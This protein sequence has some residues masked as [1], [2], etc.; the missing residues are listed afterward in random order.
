MTEPRRDQWGRPMILQ[1]D[2]KRRG[3][4]RATTLAKTLEDEAGLANWKMRQVCVGLATRA[5][6][7]AL[8]STAN[9]DK[10]KLNNVAKSALDAAASDSRANLGTALHALVETVVQG[11]EP[12]TVLDGLAGDLDAF[13]GVAKTL[14]LSSPETFVVNDTWQVAGTFDFLV[15]VGKHWRIGDLKTGTDL[16]YSWR[17]I[18]VQLATYANAEWIYNVDADERI[19]MP[20]IDKT[21][22]V[23][24]HLPAGEARCQLFEVD[25][26]AGLE[27]AQRSLWTRNWRKAKVSWQ[28]E[29]PK[30]TEKALEA[31]L[32]ARDAPPALAEPFTT[33]HETTEAAKA[34]R[35]WLTGRI[36]AL[37]AIDGGLAA[38]QAFWPA[39][40][41]TFKQSDAHTLD[42]LALI[43]T[44]LGAAEAKVA[45][46][47]EAEAPDLD[48]RHEAKVDM[49]RT[50]PAA[51]EANGFECNVPAVR[52]DG[53]FFGPIDEGDAADEAEVLELRAKI[54]AVESLRSFVSQAAKDANATGASIAMNVPTRR[55]HAIGR[56]LLAVARDG[57]DV[58]RACC[59]HVLNTD[60]PLFPT[61]PFGQILGA[62]HAHEAEAIASLCIADVQ[63]VIGADGVARVAA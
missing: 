25:L 35:A 22:G 43:E 51:S 58:V 39:G 54:L 8:A 52:A 55:R 26:D 50:K 31:S 49:P 14:E 48:A 23:I 47:F 42:E 20:P 18:A 36:D 5:D 61:T 38:L 40:V 53:R 41:A 2:G 4:T 27:A 15:R 9:G 44:A 7:L 28:I 56:I 29:T 24:V 59:A 21:R 57:E 62:L 46:P 45:A 30:A 60:A 19:A 11:G 10:R 33:P 6:L 16:S 32:A 17:S 63:L 3:Y 34:K 12:L 1:P 13:R 37:R